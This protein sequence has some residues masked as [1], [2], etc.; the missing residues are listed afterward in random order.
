MWVG[1]DGVGLGFITEAVKELLMNVDEWRQQLSSV[2]GVV[3][4]PLLLLTACCC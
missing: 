4:D 2:E 1:Y 3:V